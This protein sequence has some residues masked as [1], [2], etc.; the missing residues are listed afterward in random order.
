[1]LAM[2]TSF[3]YLSRDIDKKQNSSLKDPGSQPANIKPASN[4]KVLIYFSGG[5]YVFI[6]AYFAN[7]N[8]CFF[9][10]FYVN[11]SNSCSSA[12]FGL[13]I[14]L[15]DI[16]VQTSKKRIA[17]WLGKHLHIYK[18]QKL[19]LCWSLGEEKLHRYTKNYQNKPLTHFLYL[20]P[21]V[22]FC[23]PLL[24]L[25]ETRTDEK[26][27]MIKIKTTTCMSLTGTK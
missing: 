26:I 16:F 7:V 8:F 3:S 21:F 14:A 22:H 25:Y 6:F 4:L 24:M 15:R 5:L 13:H 27:G 10:F 11:K 18:A 17:V 9:F 12:E 1:M 19:Y 23:V 20:D 2:R